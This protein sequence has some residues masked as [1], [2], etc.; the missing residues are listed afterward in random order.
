MAIGPTTVRRVRLCAKPGCFN[1]AD[2]GAALCRQHNRPVYPAEVQN[3]ETIFTKEETMQAAA[4]EVSTIDPQIDIDSA[5]ADIGALE[6]QRGQ[7]WLDARRGSTTA[8]KELT[9][10]EVKL[11]ARRR[12]LE[13]AMAAADALTR[14]TEAAS[15]AAAFGERAGLEAERE[16]AEHRLSAHLGAVETQL[17]ALASAIRDALLASDTAYNAGIAL[18]QQLGV[19]TRTRD[20]VEQRVGHVLRLAGLPGF[21]LASSPSGRE[22]LT[23]E[24]TP[25]PVPEPRA[26]LPPRRDVRGD[27]TYPGQNLE[28]RAIVQ[29]LLQ[30]PDGRWIE[31][32]IGTIDWP[33]G[34]PPKPKE[35]LK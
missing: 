4:A 32:P 9:R 24:A 2:E 29:T 25:R 7:L 31:V 3:R 22:P 14:E 19:S 33:D 27:A 35:A 12:D 13:L 16:T 10:V 20:R 11:T 17:E 34:R 6:R 8:T 1:P 15:E 28:S 30:A 26:P 18:G 23:G 5:K 21:D